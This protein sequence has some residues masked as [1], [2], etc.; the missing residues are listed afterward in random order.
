MCVCVYVCVCVRQSFAS[1]NVYKYSGAFA[2]RVSPQGCRRATCI[3]RRATCILRRA[4]CIRRNT[5]AAEPH[6]KNTWRSSKSLFSSTVKQLLMSPAVLGIADAPC[7]DTGKRTLSA[8][9]FDPIIPQSLQ[10]KSERERARARE[11]EREKEREC[12]WRWYV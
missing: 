1:S 3:S 6:E 8:R 4:T 11:R 9:W 2:K 12:M 7:C 5:Y 10:A